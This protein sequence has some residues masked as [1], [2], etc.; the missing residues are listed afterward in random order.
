[1]DA[2]IRTTGRCRDCDEELAHCHG[3]FVTHEDGSWECTDVGCDGPVLLHRW[4]VS[5]EDLA[6]GC[7][8]LAVAV[9]A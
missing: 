7:C 4:A 2:A 1:M 8:G 9:T 5:C 6:G 3:T